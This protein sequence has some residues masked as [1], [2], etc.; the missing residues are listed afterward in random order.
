MTATLLIQ[1]LL[2]IVGFIGVL[3]VHQLMKIATAVQ[4]IQVTIGI[5]SN[6]HNNLKDRVE[7]LEKE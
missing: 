7:K 4:Q 2:G 5:L 3:M 6:D 1:I